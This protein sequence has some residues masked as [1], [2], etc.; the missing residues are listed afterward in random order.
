MKF[1]TSAL[2]ADRHLFLLAAGNAEAH[3]DVM[4]LGHGGADAR[5]IGFSLRLAEPEV[6]G[7]GEKRVY[8]LDG[9]AGVKFERERLRTLRVRVEVVG[10]R[11]PPSA[12]LGNKAVV[13]E[14]VVRVI[15]A[16][17]KYSDFSAEI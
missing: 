9:D 15:D 1:A 17:K 14:M 11:E 8:G 6:F 4:P 12:V 2:E 7:G 3:G 16:A 13:S 5:E 10:R